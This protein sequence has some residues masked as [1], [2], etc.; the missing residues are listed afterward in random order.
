M[1][2]V[3]AL[4]IPEVLI[5]IASYLAIPDLAVA[6]QV[7]KT[8]FPTFAGQLY[9][10]IRESHFRGERGDTLLKSMPQYANFI[11]KL[12]IPPFMSLKEFYPGPNLTHLVAFWPPYVTI[13]NVGVILEILKQNPRLEVLEIQCAPKVVHNERRAAEMVKTIASLK[14]LTCLELK[15]MLGGTPSHARLV[16]YLVWSLPMIEYLNF[17]VWEGRESIWTQVPSIGEADQLQDLADDGVIDTSKMLRLDILRIQTPGLLFQSVIKILNASPQLEYLEWEESNQYRTS[18]S[19]ELELLAHTLH[20]SCP[21][22][23]DLLLGCEW[24]DQDGLYYLLSRS[25]PLA[26]TRY[27]SKPPIP[28]ASSALSSSSSSWLRLRSLYMENVDIQDD[29]VLEVIWSGQE[30]L[31]E[32]LVLLELYCRGDR[33]D[34]YHGGPLVVQILGTFR[35]LESL[36]LENITVEAHEFFFKEEDGDEN[37]TMIGSSSDPIV[38]P[39]PL[40]PLSSQARIIQPW[41]SENLKV[42]KVAIEGVGRFWCPPGLVLERDD[43][44]RGVEPVDPEGSTCVFPLYYPI[45]VQLDKYPKLDQNG[46]RFMYL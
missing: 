25:S 8:F 9:R 18:K 14:N 3:H 34:N 44:M 36:T 27:S 21:K 41:A 35:K 17:T 16:E 31:K 5:H 4:D 42:L 10:Y 19:S 29:Q 7:S 23:A 12:D 40:D 11:Q 43:F 22:V 15:N 45:K 24:I 20:D 26:M 2:P 33:P 39:T 32:T 38:T 13:A 37:E 1:A 6:C 30:I 46:I 28:A